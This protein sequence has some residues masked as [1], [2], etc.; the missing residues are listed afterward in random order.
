[1]A[2]VP[3]A[4]T[5]L[6]IIAGSGSDAT[7]IPRALNNRAVIYTGNISYSLY[8]WHWPIIMFVR[9]FF[10]REQILIPTALLLT[11]ALSAI[12][13]RYVE[14]PILASGWLTQR[15]AKKELGYIFN[16]TFFRNFTAMS[17]AIMVTGAIIAA[18]DWA[19]RTFDASRTATTPA[20]GT[21]S[22][23]VQPPMA[24]QLVEGI[25]S[26]INSAKLR[27]SWGGLRP[28]VSRVQP[29]VGD[30]VDNCWN[31]PGDSPR[32]CVRGNPNAK[33]TIAVLGDSIALNF[34]FAID[35][36]VQQHPD[37]DMAVYAKLGCPAPRVPTSAPD[38][39]DYADCDRFRNWATTQINEQR[40][41][42]VWLISAVPRKLRGVAEQDTFGVWGRGLSETL[43][44][45]TG[46]RDIFVVTPPPEGRDL[47]F[48]SR[49]FNEPKDCSTV[50]SERWIKNRDVLQTSTELHGRTFIDT[51]M[52]FCDASGY[53]PAVIGE[54]IPR[55]DER[56]LTFDYAKFLAPLIAAW[57]LSS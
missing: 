22:L 54:Y 19:V 27:N 32:T 14:R 12:S 49:P 57:V 34:S 52:W 28:D 30:I 47:A 3:T 55:R 45:L 18:G 13:Y 44:E 7:V 4:A 25:Q 26:D 31:R 53:C 37:W 46:V 6:V 43:D 2:I 16:R 39:S 56:H 15:E 36:F 23:Q 40:P 42:A 35:E 41:D 29:Y 9:A 10:P 11:I 21:L 48:C 33:H 38:G 20:E 17:V 1:M 50:I 51:G 8:L 5:A 24:R